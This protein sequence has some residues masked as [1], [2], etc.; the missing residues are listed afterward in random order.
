MIFPNCDLPDELT[1][2]EQEQVIY[3]MQE[4]DYQEESQVYTEG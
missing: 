3:G 1:K 2:E 4:D